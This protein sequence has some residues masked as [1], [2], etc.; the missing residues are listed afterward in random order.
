MS[1]VDLLDLLR[2]AH[3]DNVEK[4]QSDAKGG[5]ENEARKEE[6]GCIARGVLQLILDH[7]PSIKRHHLQQRNE[8]TAEVLK[9]SIAVPATSSVIGQ[10]SDVGCTK[11]GE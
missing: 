3:D 9:M 1:A 10:T 5:A 4:E 8:A 11:V 6:D 7:R 2:H